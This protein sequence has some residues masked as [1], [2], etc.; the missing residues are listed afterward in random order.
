MNFIFFS[1]F[2]FFF[3]L[4]FAILVNQGKVHEEG[5]VVFDTP[6]FNNPMKVS[7]TACKPK[8]QISTMM[9]CGCYMI[10]FGVSKDMIGKK[11]TMKNEE[12]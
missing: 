9:L 4:F 7:N 12:F 10:E 1:F 8:H 11:L 6:N 3:L 2:N 5:Y